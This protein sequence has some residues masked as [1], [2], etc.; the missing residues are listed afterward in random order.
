MK[1]VVYCFWRMSYFKESWSLY[2]KHPFAAVLT[3]MFRRSGRIGL[4]RLNRIEAPEGDNCIFFAIGFLGPLIHSV[5][6]ALNWHNRGKSLA[7]QLII[8]NLKEFVHLVLKLLHFIG[9]C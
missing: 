4:R 9:L 6:L 8:V 2:L 5:R 7:F 3:L 1:E